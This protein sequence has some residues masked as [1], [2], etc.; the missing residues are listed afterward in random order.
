MGRAARCY[1]QKGPF[2]NRRAQNSQGGC[3]DRQG[4]LP[5]R[6]SESGSCDTEGY[7]VGK[8]KAFFEIEMAL[9]DDIHATGEP[10]ARYLGC[11]AACGRYMASIVQAGAA[12]SQGHPA[13]GLQEADNRAHHSVVAELPWE[14]RNR[15]R[16]RGSP[17]PR[18]GSGRF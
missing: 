12:P 8:D 17:P 11:P 2:V 7:A 9:Q 15:T 6:L 14:C 10:V 18:H 4:T 5:L 16:L 3:H 13:A 1:G